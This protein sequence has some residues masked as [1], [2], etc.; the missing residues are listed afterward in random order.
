[1]T[2]KT[3]HNCIVLK[4]REQESE[5]T[6]QNCFHS[7]LIVILMQGAN[8]V[9]TYIGHLMN[10]ETTFNTNQLVVTSYMYK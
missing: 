10:L 9:Y 2:F 5:K 4:N 1:M 6:F 7:Y 3:T 8:Q